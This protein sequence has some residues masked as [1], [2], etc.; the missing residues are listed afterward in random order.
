MGLRLFQ[1]HGARG[2]W[3]G[4]Y[5]CLPLAAALTV[6]V[7]ARGQEPTPAPEVSAWQAGA[8]QAVARA[9]ALFAAGKY[10]AA[11]PEFMRA[12]RAL[13]GDARQLVLL[14]NIAVCHEHSARYD[15]ALVFYARYLREAKL[16]EAERAR[17][18]GVVETLRNLV[19]EA[20]VGSNVPALVWV[21]GRPVGRAPGV[22]VLPSGQH[23]IEL[24]AALY[25][26]ARRDLVIAAGAHY[27]LRF[28]LNRLSQYRGLSPVYAWVAG[29]LCVAALATGLGFGLLA[30]EGDAGARQHPAFVQPGDAERVGRQQVA[31]N[32]G[33][34]VAGGLAATALVLA[35][36]ARAGDEPGSRASAA[37]RALP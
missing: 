8:R 37:T 6:A 18:V 26:S 25:E 13:E 23:L 20:R 21:D 4:R 34:G 5:V 12:Y 19:A 31:A 2:Q 29:G 17:V 27:A 1:K 36:L 11:L 15:Q 10:D 35:L 7:Q 22:F 9:E 16:S 33:F 24:Q 28:E 14:N 32:V 3:M 30:K